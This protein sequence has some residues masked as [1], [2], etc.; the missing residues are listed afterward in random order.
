MVLAIRRYL[1]ADSVFFWYDLI[2]VRVAKFV[3]A[4][5]F[6]HAAK[7]PRLRFTSEKRRLVQRARARSIS[8]S[9]RDAELK[10]RGAINGLL[11]QHAIAVF[12][13]LARNTRA[14]FLIELTVEYLSSV[15]KTV[16]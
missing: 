8:D 16:S 12:V 6:V 15:M 3:L 13:T 10:W 1:F 9:R 2:V 11:R 4:R 14:S 7:Q 5:S